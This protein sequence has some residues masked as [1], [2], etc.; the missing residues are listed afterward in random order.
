M[1]P[2]S[3]DI[4]ETT[5][6]SIAETSEDTASEMVTRM[7][8]QQP[9]IL[10]YLME[11]GEDELNQEEREHL[12]Y[13]GIVV[14]QI[15]LQGSTT[16]PMINE[17]IL[18]GVEELNIKMLEYVEGEPDSDFV[19]TIQKIINSYN[20]PEVLRYIVEALMEDPEE[21]ESII[22]EENIGLL[23]IYLKTVID[24]FDK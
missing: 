8:E 17:E 5:W 9:L 14:W 2:I 4:V 10:A 15:M 6:N 22:R 21:E 16:P 1:N 23:F 12:L 13:L 24:C 18:E 11:A 19:D 20:Q 3:V 7:G